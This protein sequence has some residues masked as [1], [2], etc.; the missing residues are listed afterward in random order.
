M[1]R[2]KPAQEV[3]VLHSTAT[4]FRAGYSRDETKI[5]ENEYIEAVQGW[6]PGEQRVVSSHLASY[7]TST[8]PEIF[9]VQK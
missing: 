3:A 6:Q 7:L 5:S 8:F 2:P 4:P 9:L 1:A